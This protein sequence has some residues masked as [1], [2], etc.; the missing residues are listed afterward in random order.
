MKKLLEEEKKV[1]E[2]DSNLEEF[3][4]SCKEAMLGFS[5]AINLE[6][7]TRDDAEEAKYMVQCIEGGE[8]MQMIVTNGLDRL[9]KVPLDIKILDNHRLKT[10][11]EGT[12]TA[13]F[14]L[15]RQALDTKSLTFQCLPSKKEEPDFLL[16]VH[17][18]LMPGARITGTF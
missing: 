15:L 18:P 17:Y 4:N 11:I 13:Y 1:S 14:S 10:G 8:S 5:Q 2:K 12:W 7:E 9:F 3:Q 6:D 16:K